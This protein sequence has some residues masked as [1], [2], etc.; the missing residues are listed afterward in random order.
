[1]QYNT[2]IQTYHTIINIAT[3]QLPLHIFNPLSI[4]YDTSHTM[5]ACLLINNITDSIITILFYTKNKV[6]PCEANGIHICV[7][8]MI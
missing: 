3:I 7:L 2:T 5:L 8:S 4:V 1:M 6:W